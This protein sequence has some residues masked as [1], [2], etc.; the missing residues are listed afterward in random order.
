V[1]KIRDARI[2][3]RRKPRSANSLE[4]RTEMR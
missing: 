4:A 3:S 1:A 2:R